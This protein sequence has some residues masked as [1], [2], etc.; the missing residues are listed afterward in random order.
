MLS[1]N[2]RASPRRI[3]EH[4][5]E[6][7]Y[8]EALGLL[9]ACTCWARNELTTDHVFTLARRFEETARNTYDCGDNHEP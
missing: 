2:K 9:V 1:K 6:V 7:L 5:F 4:K 3:G 8:E